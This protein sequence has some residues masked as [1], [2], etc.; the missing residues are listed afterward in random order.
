MMCQQEQFRAAVTKT[1]ILSFCSQGMS[2]QIPL[3]FVKDLKEAT[4]GLS[5]R[6]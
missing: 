5:E 3:K 4:D 6:K 2:H 1:H